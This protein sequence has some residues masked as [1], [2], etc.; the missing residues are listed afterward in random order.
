MRR[1]LVLALTALLLSPFP[2]AALEAWG[3]NGHRF[4]TDKAID[5]LPPELHPFFDK[6][7]AAVVEH[8]IDPDTY[9]TMGWA[10]EPPR[11]FLDMDNWGPFPFSELPHDYAAAVAK[12]GEDFVVKNGT[13]PWRVEEIFGR[14]RDAF[15]QVSRQEF[16]RENVKLFSAVLSHYVADSFQPFHASANFDGQLTGQNGIHA[17][18]ETEMFDR[19]VSRLRITAAPPQ[20]I[21]SA[22]EFAF[23][24]L[25]DSFKEVDPILSTDR[26]ATQGRTVY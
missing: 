20:T 7:R 24:T 13:L 23:S 22:R 8:S 11:H 15:K 26:E 12:R 9:R 5:Q 21:P 25:T 18:F 17:R 4:I 16:A 6:Y 2:R 14:L 19:F 1:I 10:E 3:F